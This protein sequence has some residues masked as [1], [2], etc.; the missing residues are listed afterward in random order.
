MRFN[1]I[2]PLNIK[3]AKYTE[4]PQLLNLN[5]LFMIAAICIIHEE[6]S[7]DT[8]DINTLRLNFHDEL[9]AL[10]PDLEESELNAS[11]GM[12]LA[13]RYKHPDNQNGLL[14][15]HRVNKQHGVTSA[16]TY[17]V[18]VKLFRQIFGDPT[19]CINQHLTKSTT[20]SSAA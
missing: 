8:V 9:C 17:S 13:T 16:Y 2:K 15:R 6:T 12:L 1:N 11:L 18:E 20:L 7:A 10:R 19:E 4:K 5:Y 3:T 14:K